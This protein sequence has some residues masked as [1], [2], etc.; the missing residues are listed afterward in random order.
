MVA[1]FHMNGI[2]QI[3]IACLVACIGCTVMPP[4][5][6]SAEVEGVAYIIPVEGAI[7]KALLYVI[8][9]GVRQAEAE[10]ANAIIFAVDTPGGQL[11]ATDEIIRLLL[12]IRIPTYTFVKAHAFSAGAI[13]AFATDR[14]YMAPGSVI[15]AATPVMMAPLGGA[16]EMPDTMEEKTV[17]A[18][19]AM[20]RSAAQSKGHDAQLAEAMVRREKEFRIGEE[21]ISPS[22]E[23]LTLTNTEAEQRVG[24]DRRPLL[25]SG[26][27]NDIEELLEAVGLGGS[28]IVTLEVT[29]AERIARVIASLSVLLLAGGLLG[30]YIE[31]RTPGFGIPGIAGMICLMIFFWGHHI[32]GLAG[33]EDIVIFM[34]GAALLLVEI[35]FIPGF[36]IVGI[37]GFIF[38]ILGLFSAMLPQLPGI[39]DI[40]PFSFPVPNLLNAFTVI[41][42]AL[43]LTGIIALAIFRHAPKTG[44]FKWVA[45]D[46][47]TSKDAGY[48]AT[49][50][51][52]LPAGTRGRALTPL[53]PGGAGEFDDRRLDIVTRGEFIGA[54][55]PLRIVEARGRRIV[56][57]KDETVGD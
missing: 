21:L 33:M 44:V 3:A 26:T 31:F 45:L 40:S 9:R 27:V 7:E 24:D 34:I 37:A 25:S 55:T 56:V 13:I 29:A 20:V 17:S 48:T 35:F 51:S 41:S 53:H 23:L 50:P 52:D 39:S 18:V 15:G 32:A 46:K 22:G 49:A 11:D 8:R 6:R 12:R 28:R 43:V 30:L 5:C 57:E 2:R 36:G 19:S 38:M 14:I 47:A 1:N 10:Q 42:G 16:Q 4:A 54:G